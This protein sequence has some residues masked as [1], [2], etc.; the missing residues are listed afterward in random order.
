MERVFGGLT[1]LAI[2]LVTSE[3]TLAQS[4]PANPGGQPTAQSVLNE[5]VQQGTG[6]SLQPFFVRTRRFGLPIQLLQSSYQVQAVQL[7]VSLDGGVHWQLYAQQ[8]V[9]AREFLFQA[10]HDGNFWFASKTVDTA[11]VVRP[12]GAPRAEQWVVVDTI[13]P[14]IRLQAELAA[15]GEI[16]IVW[17]IADE[18]LDPKSLRLEYREGILSAWQTLADPLAH[19]QKLPLAHGTTATTWQGQFQW[20]PVVQSKVIEL[21]M[22]AADLAGN[23]EI[24]IQRVFLPK[25]SNAELSPTPGGLSPAT[26]NS[27]RYS[28]SAAGPTATP[29]VPAGATPSI[30]GF[31]T[32]S[33]TAPSSV[34][35]STTD[36]TA[37]APTGA[38]LPVTQQRSDTPLAA[39]NSANGMARG[40]DYVPPAGDWQPNRSATGYEVNPSASAASTNPAENALAQA[41]RSVAGAG[42]SSTERSD[43]R[44]E[45]PRDNRLPNRL[46]TPTASGTESIGETKTIARVSNAVAPSPSGK[47]VSNP[48]Y[49]QQ[50]R[51]T[52]GSTHEARD[53]SPENTEPESPGSLTNRSAN[54]STSTPTAPT[55]TQ[56]TVPEGQAV[57][58]T[59]QRRFQLEYDL[60]ASHANGAQEVQLW[61]TRDG[62]QTW[63]KWGADIDKQSPFNVE[64]D[65]DGIYG[66]RVVVI[67]ANG[68]ATDVPRSGAPADLWV[69]VD[70]QP[71]QATIS[72][73]SYGT[74]SHL[75]ELEIR[76][77]AE[78]EHLASR[79]VNLY[80][81]LTA[82]G[83][84]TP[85]AAGLPNTGQYY[86]LIDASVPKSVFVRLE[87]TDEANNR[88][89]QIT[90][91][92][93]DLST[94]VPRA[95][96][97]DVKSR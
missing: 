85:I 80:F 86:W 22:S 87:V 5:S 69:I 30:G 6:T 84:W 47:L 57:R 29:N 27:S 67:A 12:E 46:S 11:N 55:G 77:Q 31:T 42:S 45:W 91:R 94:L 64:V 37:F 21:R 18:H 74:G 95:R 35:A 70:T 72:S 17:Q 53:A 8:P 78:D 96:I 3:L 1:W 40:T 50:P 73:V 81:G 38:S 97:R 58:A 2:G 25:P 51:S 39:T 68:L 49:D 43:A 79:P 66:F 32:A 24:E 56:P 59:A 33:P 52:S 15:N 93:I 26:G 89:Q 7:Y 76:W 75:G 92:P 61:G 88:T 4:Y 71:P 13:R 54:K 10:P 34:E 41:A 16:R 63:E 60:E 48:F 23:A 82:E 28:A 20:R 90:P 62:G 14:Q 83:P 44:T 19:T 9:G 36:T 65:R